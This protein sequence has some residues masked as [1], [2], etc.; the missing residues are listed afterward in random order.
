MT[1]RTL[2]T[3]F[4]ALALLGLAVP[5][6]AATISLS[7]TTSNVAPGGTVSLALIADFSGDPTLGGGVDIF[8]MVS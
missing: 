1:V 8:S 5:A 4:T 2:S 7:P 6:S 3:V